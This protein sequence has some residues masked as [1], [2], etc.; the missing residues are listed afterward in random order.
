MAWVWEAKNG[1]AKRGAGRRADGWR[2]RVPLWQ[3][4]RATWQA[5][6][7]QGLIDQWW[8]AGWQLTKGRAGG[9]LSPPDSRQKFL[10]ERLRLSSLWCPMNDRRQGSLQDLA[11][12]NVFWLVV[13][14]LVKDVIL[15]TTNSKNEVWGQHVKEDKRG[16]SWIK[17]SRCPSLGFAEGLLGGLK[18]CTP[19]SFILL[20][21]K[22]RKPFLFPSQ[23]ERARSN[24]G[25][26]GNRV[27][28]PQS[29]S[30][31]FWAQ[32]NLVMGLVWRGEWGKQRQRK[33]EFDFLL[34]TPQIQMLSYDNPVTH[35]KC[36]TL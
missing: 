22:W 36:Q 30:P 17:R 2:G 14:K 5:V 19:L 29:A 11:E 35:T 12:V 9:D 27:P 13:I 32:L 25:A 18:P 34:Y 31:T 15:T 24:T 33:R 7:G 6:G 20:P 26:T 1:G 16:E 28:N 21:G 23:T 10:S 3:H 4:Q 8:E